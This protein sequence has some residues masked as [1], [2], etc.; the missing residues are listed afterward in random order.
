MMINGPSLTHQRERFWGWPGWNHLGYFALLGLGQTVWFGMIYGAADRLTVAREFRVR[1]H[2]DAELNL[3]FV[4]EAAAVYM[5]I[6]ALFLMV[7]FILRTR[8]Q[9]LALT[10]T[11]AAVTFCGGV[12]FLLLPAEAAFPSPHDLGRWPR[13]FQFAD[14]LN[15]EYNMMPSLHVALNVVCVA[16][17]SRR[18]TRF[19]K[20]ILWTWATAISIST[21]LTH[22]H[23]IVDVITGFVLGLVATR[24]VYNRHS[25]VAYEV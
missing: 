10:A 12:C 20:T 6:Y 21:L 15:L 11:L 4:P 22:Q 16:V 17:F 13:L 8:Q 3:P 5:S 23:H 1:I 9:I 2:T 24:L 7:P 25:L 19:G 18:A 14:W